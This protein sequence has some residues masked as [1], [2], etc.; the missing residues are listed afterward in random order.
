MKGGEREGTGRG[1]ERERGEGREN[2]IVA[3]YTPKR[4]IF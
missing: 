1:E 4:T 3:K 2:K